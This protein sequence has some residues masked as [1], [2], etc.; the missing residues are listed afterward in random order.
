ME[1]FILGMKRLFTGARI[2]YETPHL[3]RYIYIPLI[4]T[5][6]L[7]TLIVVLGLALLDNYIKTLPP[8]EGI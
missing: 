2:I 1:N 3:R 4:L 8:T 6:L 7:Y 5:V